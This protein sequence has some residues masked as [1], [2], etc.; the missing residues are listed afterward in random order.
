M[1]R[2]KHPSQVQAYGFVAMISSAT[3]RS[4]TGSSDIRASSLFV[5]GAEQDELDIMQLGEGEGGA[6]VV[7]VELAGVGK[8]A[9]PSW[10]LR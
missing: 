7:F 10:I 2:L 6:D 8:M 3:R 4:V 9:R 1:N 5:V